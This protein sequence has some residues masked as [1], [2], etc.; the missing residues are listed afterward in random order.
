MVL[1]RPRSIFRHALAICEAKGP[2]AGAFWRAALGQLS[3]EIR[4]GGNLR[5]GTLAILLVP[6]EC[7][8][9]V[10]DSQPEGSSVAFYVIQ[11]T[12]ALKV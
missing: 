8:A 1:R 10:C 6:V 4:A 9:Q 7:A 2:T 5:L 12:A 11:A 3:H